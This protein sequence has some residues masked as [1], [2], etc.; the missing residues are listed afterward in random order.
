MFQQEGVHF[1]WRGVAGGVGV[2]FIRRGCLELVEG[3]AAYGMFEPL[4]RQQHSQCS[5]THGNSIYISLKPSEL[6]CIIH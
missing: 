5:P 1:K 3:G 6:H 4:T 2:N